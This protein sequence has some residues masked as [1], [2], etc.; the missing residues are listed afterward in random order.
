MLKPQAKRETSLAK[1]PG[2]QVGG[3]LKATEPSGRGSPKYMA[4]APL[5]CLPYDGQQRRG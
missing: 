1:I 5:V 4:N 3:R 2:L